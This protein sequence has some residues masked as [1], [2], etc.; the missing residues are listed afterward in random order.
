MKSVRSVSRFFSLFFA[1]GCP[2]LPAASFEK[3]V[4]AALYCLCSFVQDQLTLVGLPVRWAHAVWTRRSGAPQWVQVVGHPSTASLGWPKTPRWAQE[5][6]DFQNQQHVYNRC[7]LIHGKNYVPEMEPHERPA[8][9]LI[10]SFLS[11]ANFLDY[12]LD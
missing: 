10:R 8:N 5:C 12:F 3:T 7:F 11:L 9:G 6:A 2:V 1:C 4:L